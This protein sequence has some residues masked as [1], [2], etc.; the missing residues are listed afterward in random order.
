VIAFGTNGGSAVN[1]VEVDAL[2]HQCSYWHLPTAFHLH[3]SLKWIWVSTPLHQPTVAII[4]ICIDGAIAPLFNVFS[5]PVHM[6]LQNINL[7]CI[8]FVLLELSWNGLHLDKVPAIK[9]AIVV[10]N[11][12]WS[13]V[14]VCWSFEPILLGPVSDVQVPWN[15]KLIVTSLAKARDTANCRAEYSSIW[16]W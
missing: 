13:K 2:A 11:H 7:N 12:H 8:D 1:P 6:R 9:V 10:I 16:G 4:F 3:L 15:G 14:A 5:N